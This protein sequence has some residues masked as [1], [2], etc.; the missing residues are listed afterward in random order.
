MAIVKPTGAVSSHTQSG[1][2]ISTFS[3]NHTVPAGDDR[4]V[5]V[6]VCAWRNSDTN[7]FTV[8]PT[9]DSNSMS[10]VYSNN[11]T[12]SNRYYLVSIW[13]IL[14][15]AVT[16]SPV[17]VAGT[18]ATNTINDQIVFTI[19]L[20]GVHQTT[21]TGNTGVDVT[22]QARSIAITTGADNAWLLAGTLYYSGTA[23][24]SEVNSTVEDDEQTTGS[25]STADITAG[26]Y[27]LVCT[28]AGEYTIEAT[29]DGENRG[30]MAA[31]EVR[32][33]V[34]A[35]V[36]NAQPAY[37]V[38]RATTVDAQPAYTV[39]IATTAD[40][41]PAYT[42]GRDTASDAQPAYTLGVAGSVG[43]Q[44]A[45]VAGV[46]TT[47]DS[48]A[49]YTAGGINSVD[50]QPAYAAGRV[51]AS[52][53]VVAYTAGRATTTDNQPAYIAGQNG[54]ADAQP[55]YAS[56]RVTV[57]DSQPAHTAGIATATDNQPAYVV[58]SPSVVMPSGGLS[59]YA[60]SGTSLTA[61]SFSHTVPAGDRRAVF[62]VVCAWRN[63]D[64]TAFTVAPTF[65]G[66]A[67]TEVGSF[68]TTT[69]N[70][71]YLVSIWR[72]LAPSVT[73]EPVIVAGTYSGA[74]IND[75]VVHAISLNGVDQA[76]P[77]GNIGSDTTGAEK[78][79]AITTGTDA[80]WLLGGLLVYGGVSTLS[81]NGATV[82][83]D[84]RAT[85]SGSTSDI[86]VGL[87]HL[88]CG[89][90]GEHT[91]AAETNGENRG[92]FGVIEVRADAQIDITSAQPAYVVGKSTAADSQP[93]Y[94]FGTNDVV[95]GQPAYL[96][97]G[98][99]L[100]ASQPAY[101]TGIATVSDSQPALVIGKDTATD[102]QPAYVT[103][104]PGSIASQLAYVVGVDTIAASQ[105]AYLFCG[106]TETDAQPAYLHGSA[107]ATDA[108][109]AYVVGGTDA[110]DSQ[111]AHAVGRALKSDSQPAYTVGTEGDYIYVATNGSD[112]SGD[113]SSDAPYATVNKAVSVASPGDTIALRN[114]TYNQR[115][116][117]N[118]W[119]S[120][121]ANNLLTIKA[122]N[123]GM[124]TLAGVSNTLYIVDINN[125]SW[126][127][128]QDLF[129][130]YAAGHTVPGD[131]NHPIYIRGTSSDIRITGNQI[132]KL[133]MT[134]TET[135]MK[136]DFNGG[137]R[138]VGVNASG[139]T[140][141]IEIDH[142]QI[143]G[144][145]KAVA[146]QG[147]ATFYNIH[148]NRMHTVQSCI[149]I[150]YGDFVPGRHRVAFNDFEYSYM[151]DGS[152]H[153]RDP[154]LPEH[155]I[156]TSYVFYYRNLFRNLGENAI[157]TKGAEHIFFVQNVFA[158]NLGNNNGRHPTQQTIA[159][160]VNMISCGANQITRHRVGFDNVFYD[161]SAAMATWDEDCYYNN[162][163]W[164][165]LRR[166]LVSGDT[167]DS[168]KHRGFSYTEGTGFSRIILKNNLVGRMYIGSSLRDYTG[169]DIDIDGNAYI[170]CDHV[171]YDA[172]ASSTKTSLANWRTWVQGNGWDTEGEANS[173][174]G[175]DAA[176][177]LMVNWPEFP[178][179]DWDIYDWTV[180]PTATPLYGQGVAI[181]T[182]ASTTTNSTALPVANSGPFY[183]SFGRT[184]LPQ[185]DIY[186]T[187]VGTRKVVSVNWNTDTLTLDAP[188][189][190]ANGAAIYHG[191]SATPNIGT[192]F[193]EVGPDAD[194]EESGGGGEEG[195]GEGS[196]GT[197]TAGAVASFAQA[198]SA[199]TF[200]FGATIPSGSDLA[201]FVV[202]LA[203][204]TNETAFTVTPTF[205]GEAMTEVYTATTTTTNRSYLA[206]IWR[207]LNPA[208]G[209][210]TVAGT[211]SSNPTDQVVFALPL[212]G[213][214]QS[215]PT[216]NT[217][218]DTSG[219]WDVALTTDID[220]AWLIGGTVVYGGDNTLGVGGATV[221]DN[222]QATNTSATTDIT[223][224]LFHLVTTTLGSHTLQSTANNDTKGLAAAVV[225]RPAAA[226]TWSGSQ[227]AYLAGG[228]NVSA[229]QPAYVTGQTTTSDGQ[230]AHATGRALDS[231]TQ[232]AYVIGKTTTSDSQ[233][234]FT[235]GIVALAADSQPAHTTG[236]DTASGAAVAYTKGATM[237]ADAQPAYLVGKD[238]ATDAQPAYVVGV[239][240]AT[241]SQPAYTVGANGSIEAQPAYVV[242]VSGN[243]AVQPAYAIGQDTTAAAQPAYTVG[244][245]IAS[246]SQPAYA[247]GQGGASAARP[248]YTVGRQ[249]ATD[250]QAA[251]LVG[252]DTDVGEQIAYAIGQ[253]DSTAAQPVYLIGRANDSA[254]QPAYTIGRADDN[255]E[256]PAYTTGRDTDAAAQP[257]Y[258][259]GQATD[260]GDQTGYAVGKDTDAAS[261]PAYLFCGTI[262]RAEQTAYLFATSGL[263]LDWYLSDSAAHDWELSDEAAH[264]WT[265]T[266]ETM[267]DWELTDN[268]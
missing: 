151:E 194:E 243:I 216:G 129:V 248:G 175:T 162:F 121:D 99:I 252:A 264:E 47:S 125:S 1:S 24:L 223:G 147:R 5:F 138:D 256:Q 139:T 141:R 211:Y 208:V 130:Q 160:S 177:T 35:N 131:R 34:A 165:N 230:P 229:E 166:D 94:A 84:E 254:A 23:A 238:T 171:G 255:A 80:A 217:G 218:N 150:R 192:F 136:N 52:A 209:A 187:G 144:I 79:V 116:Y 37:M 182:A 81:P 146:S 128:I 132:T 118:N 241:D 122:E 261:Q 59:T 14:A 134:P 63:S 184:D 137:Y 247:I 39:G 207:T 50:S 180:K 74:A 258:T 49:A 176:S 186:I 7:P 16:G 170:N 185:Q 11:T 189:T 234:A 133:G 28:T 29:S 123:A 158:S 179:G 206:S 142:N 183:G 161:N 263:P 71:Y 66:A 22:G 156:D 159:G 222:Q 195:G 110:I 172:K 197:I 212:I 213:V 112:G 262:V 199:S 259:I 145:N 109:P 82:E 32:P 148:H 46:S 173:Y 245:A 237:A 93:A 25:G 235:T 31:I 126:I 98:D 174:A 113:G 204:K 265:L 104:V 44:P 246:D 3:F 257:A 193:F 69:N 86:T 232:P 233:P 117:I 102:S 103:G 87:Y 107:P 36:S 51:T 226:G 9:F 95:S 196:S 27:H 45:Y 200:S 152:Q 42:I 201:L 89:A 83:D 6:V 198:G 153:Q 227:A 127:V 2:G 18:Y 96:F 219:D 8:T 12:T 61:F 85:G 240:T 124:A 140:A 64:T 41:Q 242:G 164:Y 60:A 191:T 76:T 78:S 91:I 178:T 149:G 17:T 100:T 239:T 202:V 40:A 72:I 228:L 67:M 143:R 163:V 26:L 48:Q 231:Q 253:A 88:V 33:S 168:L 4:A 111:P 250:A 90:A 73:G 10:E 181:T 154:A 68:T 249:D 75:Q 55:A 77:T 13:R 20:N 108:Q 214:D 106:L 260:T 53:T 210:G 266:D 101:A 92:V 236:R 30:L 221:K 188:A 43:S 97:G 225:V 203:W 268:T 38:G 21:P 54:I 119:N 58:G 190:V 56:G 169:T 224:G 215:T 70:R 15:P 114:G 115:A 167:A 267:H 251:F 65:D 120:G 205:N 57:T 62:V 155:T 220:N 244:D 105:L 19:S 135:Q 157:D